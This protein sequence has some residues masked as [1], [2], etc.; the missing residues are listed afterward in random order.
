MVGDLLLQ[1]DLS[2][3][4]QAFGGPVQ[5]FLTSVFWVLTRMSFAVFITQFVLETCI[6]QLCQLSQGY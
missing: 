5:M 6:I 2:V 3:G 1:V 4:F